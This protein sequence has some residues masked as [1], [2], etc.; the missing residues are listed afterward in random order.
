MYNAKL[1]AMMKQYGAVKGLKSVCAACKKYD[2]VYEKEM[3]YV[4]MYNRVYYHF[5]SC[6][7]E[8][9][10]VTNMPI[11]AYMEE[12]KVV[13]IDDCKTMEELYKRLIERV[14]FTEMKMESLKARLIADFN[15]N[16]L[17][18]KRL[19]SK[20]DVNYCA[21]NEALDLSW[22]SFSLLRDYFGVYEY[23]SYD[24]YIDEDF[25]GTYR[26]IEE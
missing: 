1:N 17:L 13:N 10:T 12:R 6:M 21:I 14:G 8:F 22:Y 18:Y 4:A 25:K 16:Q 9:D 20:G 19:V 5:V 24:F 15:A 3:V 7:N 23:T 2:E 26:Q 11:K